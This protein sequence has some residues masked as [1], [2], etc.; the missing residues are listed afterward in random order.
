MA[1]KDERKITATGSSSKV[2]SKTLREGSMATNPKFTVDKPAKKA[3]TKYSPAPMSEK[4]KKTAARGGS[5][6]QA[7]IGIKK[8]LTKIAGAAGK[9]AG[10]VTSTAK[11]VAKAE[12]GAAKKAVGFATK[13]AK[14]NSDMVLKG[15]KAGV[16][17]LTKEPRVGRSVGTTIKKLKE[18][19]DKASKKK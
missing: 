7:T 15:A 2:V 19:S 13:A 17:A 3:S 11:K 16:K 8:D 14:F 5:K 1:K 18:S 4:A 10:K 6:T 9:V 12:V